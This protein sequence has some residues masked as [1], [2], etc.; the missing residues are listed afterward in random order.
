MFVGGLIQS[1]GDQ[2][3]FY[4]VPRFSVTLN[5]PRHDQVIEKGNT[6]NHSDGD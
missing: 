4:I 2:F 5:N 3:T 1:T 6:C